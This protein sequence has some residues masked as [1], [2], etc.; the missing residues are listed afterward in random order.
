MTWIVGTPTIFGYAILVS[1][2]R[3]TFDG[4]SGQKRYLDCL[5]KIYP[6]SK[7]MLGGFSGSVK[8][9]FRILSLLQQ[10]SE[11]MPEDVDWSLDIIANTWWPR[12]AKRTFNMSEPEEKNLGSGIILAGA[13]PSRN[14]GA[15]PFPHSSV[16]TF[17]S[18]DFEPKKANYRQ[19]LAVGSPDQRYMQG[20]TRL[21]SSNFAFIQVSM[22]GE[23]GPGSMLAH[24]LKSEIEEAPLP[25]VSTFFQVGTASRRRVSIN[26]FVEGKFG[27][28]GEIEEGTFPPIACN[29]NEFLQLCQSSGLAADASLC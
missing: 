12:T 22:A 29:Y 28:G 17:S 26:N 16:Y 15:A 8:I 24:Y 5:Q 25:G 21:V 7:S 19:I 20:I 13:H 10:A 14:M 27:A 3:V 9:G 6:V 23:F 1:D 2:I 4:L 18:P 11:R